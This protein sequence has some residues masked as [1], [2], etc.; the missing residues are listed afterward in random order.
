MIAMQLEGNSVVKIAEHFNL[1]K[2]RV[3]QIINKPEN[4]QLKAKM[5]D[6]IAL[7]EADKIVERKK[8]R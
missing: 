5:I 7:A 4:Q 8:N 6:R 1:T 2:G 3:S